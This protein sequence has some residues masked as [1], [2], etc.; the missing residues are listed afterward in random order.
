MEDVQYFRRMDIELQ[1][2]HRVGADPYPNV[3]P[4]QIDLELT[5]YV[6]IVILQAS[7]LS[8]HDPRVSLYGSI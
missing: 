7:I 8:L 3:A 2:M 4:H 5:L 1:L 6:S